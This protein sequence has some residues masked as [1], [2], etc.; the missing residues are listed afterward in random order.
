ME[1]DISLPDTLPVDEGELAIVLANALEN[2]IH[3]N[4]LLPTKQRK[5]DQL[6]QHGDNLFRFCLGV[7]ANP[8]HCQSDDCMG[9][10]PGSHLLFLQGEFPGTAGQQTAYHLAAVLK[11]T[12]AEP[13]LT[14][15][16]QDTGI[17]YPAALQTGQQLSQGFIPGASGAAVPEYRTD[18]LCGKAGRSPAHPSGRRTGAGGV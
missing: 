2:A 12:A 11:Q 14:L 8:I 3:A 15:I 13:V 1:A 16:A 6:L 9:I 7:A 17:E 4:L 10:E 5:I 18:P